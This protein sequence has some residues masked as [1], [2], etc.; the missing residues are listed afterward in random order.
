MPDTLIFHG[1]A[2]KTVPIAQVRDFC[3]AMRQAKNRCTVLGFEG[4]GHGFFNVTNQEGRWY[5]RVLVE[6]VAFLRQHGYVE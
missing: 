2:D 4:A 3:T 5:P 6:T 1:E